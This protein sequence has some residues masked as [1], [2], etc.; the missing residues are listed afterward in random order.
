[1][2][3]LLSNNIMDIDGFL[4]CGVTVSISVVRDCE[5]LHFQFTP[6]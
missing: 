1:M 5:A 3:K 6:N 4:E 2:F